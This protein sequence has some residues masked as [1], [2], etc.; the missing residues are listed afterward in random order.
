MILALLLA[1]QILMGE[2]KRD[3]HQVVLFRKDNP[4]PSTGHTIGACP[5]YVVDHIVP[6]CWGGAD[7]PNN[8]AW[9]KQADSYKK[10]VFERQACAMKNKK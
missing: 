7:S 8:M 10:D 9:E 1:V 2:V 4:C 3:P 5:N 6:L